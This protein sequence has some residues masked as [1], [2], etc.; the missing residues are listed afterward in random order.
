M[1]E[2]EEYLKIQKKIKLK[3]SLFLH[4][5]LYGIIILFLAIINY[6]TMSRNGHW[7]VLFPAAAWGVA[8]AIHA[9]TVYGFSSIG[10]FGDDWEKKQIENELSKKGI[11]PNNR[12]LSS[13]EQ[14]DIDKHLNLKQLE[15][16]SNYDER[17][18]V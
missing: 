5:A 9:L 4:L 8:L 2:S 11:L 6:L 10:I 1:S 13:D 17:D 12:I 15:K 3:K 16:K 14:V 18:L 7:W